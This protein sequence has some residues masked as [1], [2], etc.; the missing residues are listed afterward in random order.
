[1]PRYSAVGC[2]LER[3]TPLGGDFLSRVQDII[4]GWLLYANDSPKS[5]FA[6]EKYFR[7]S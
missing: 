2:R 6:A 1:M 4:D 3:Q 7:T 5:R